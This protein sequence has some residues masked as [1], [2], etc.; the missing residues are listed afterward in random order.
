MAPQQHSLRREGRPRGKTPAERADEAAKVQ[1]RL[2][3]EATER[4]EAAAA[5]PRPG[6]PSDA[7]SGRA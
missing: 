7:G 3:R 5:K 1:Q 4:R 6:G 2:K